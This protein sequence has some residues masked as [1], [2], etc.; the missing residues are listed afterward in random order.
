MVNKSAHGTLIWAGP[1]AL[2]PIQCALCSTRLRNRQDVK[3]HEVKHQTPEELASK[4]KPRKRKAAG[5]KSEASTPSPTSASSELPLPYQS[6][7]IPQVSPR[8]AAE[9][10]LAEQHPHHPHDPSFHQ[11]HHQ[12]LQEQ[13]HQ[14]HPQHLAPSLHPS[15]V[16]SP[17]PYDM[18]MRV[19]GMPFP[20]TLNIDGSLSQNTSVIGSYSPAPYS[21]MAQNSYYPWTQN[22]QSQSGQEMLGMAP[23]GFYPTHIIQQHTGMAPP[24]H[25]AM[26]MAAVDPSGAR[27]YGVLQDAQQQATSS[28]SS[29]AMQQRVRPAN[30]PDALTIPHVSVH[31]MNTAAGY[32]QMSAAPYTGGHQR[33]PSGLYTP[34]TPASSPS[35]CYSPIQQHQQPHQASSSSRPG[36][37]FYPAQYHSPQQ[38][39]S[40]Q[41]LQQ[42]QLHH[43]HVMQQQHSTPTS[44]QQFTQQPYAQQTL[45]RATYTPSRLSADILADS[46]QQARPSSSST[47]WP[48]HHPNAPQNAGDHPTSFTSLMVSGSADPI[49]SPTYLYPNQSYS[50]GHGFPP[51][52]SFQN[53]SSEDAANT[54]QYPSANIPPSHLGALPPPPPSSATSSRRP[55]PRTHSTQSDNDSSSLS[56]STTAADPPNASFKRTKRDHLQSLLPTASSI[57]A[58]PPS[59]VD[60]A[61]SSSAR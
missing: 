16:D 37:D 1:T 15:G 4:P 51:H 19:P 2:R 28:A 42:S 6:V 32:S 17:H 12:L 52:P 60:S 3:R 30:Q 7:N 36:P 58:L 35:T 9:H 26:N 48:Q 57:D 40:E 43:H 31:S 54:S 59:P 47:G 5:G 33:Q 46:Q 8:L 44:A 20:G 18:R 11:S 21:P 14:Q 23:A 27:R 45:Q 55:N 24:Q 50:H 38:T 13:H 61:P 56:P 53:P 39:Q 10:H 34:L 22:S 49:P 41:H 25:Q 29:H